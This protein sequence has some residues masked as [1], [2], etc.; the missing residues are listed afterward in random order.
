MHPRHQEIVDHLDRHRADLRAAV[1]SVPTEH[2]ATSPAD[3]QWSVLGVLEHL[4]IVEGRIGTMIEKHLGDARDAGLRIETDSGPILPLL[5][6]AKFTDRTSKIKAS[7]AAQPKSGHAL[8]ELWQSLDSSLDRIRRLLGS[9]DGMR[10]SDVTMPHPVFGPLDLYTWFAFVGSHEGRHAAQI[11]EIGAALGAA[12]GPEILHFAQEHALAIDHLVL[13]GWAGRD[14]AAVEAHIRELEAL[15]T[16]RPSRTP[17]FYRV[18]STLLTT[19]NAIQVVANESSGEVEFV[20]VIRADGVWVGLGSDHTDRGLERH[21]VALAKQLCAK[22]VAPALWRLDDIIEHWDEIELRSW[23]YR[24]GVREAY[25]DGTVAQILPPKRLLEMYASFAAPLVE[26]GV[27]FSGTLPTLH[28]IA[29][30][31]AFEMELFDPRLR[32]RIHHRYRID[33]LPAN[34]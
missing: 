25:Q 18:A 4:V 12:H 22:V 19:A 23:T 16:P 13:A 24:D 3:G 10:L 11:R 8:G 7:E 9:A 5:D 6:I 2:H 15:G 21:S 33:V 1:A 32:R 29:P 20:L 34:A 30:A 27:L 14:Q 26:G 17:V 31:D 28:E